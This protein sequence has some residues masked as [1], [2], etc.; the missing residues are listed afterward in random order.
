VKETALLQICL[1][2][3][4]LF[5]A[6]LFHSFA[7]LWFE[8]GLNFASAA[9]NCGVVRVYSEDGSALDRLDQMTG[10]ES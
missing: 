2:T 8:F 7:A 1:V 3:N 6:S 4:D 10:D 9:N 5:F